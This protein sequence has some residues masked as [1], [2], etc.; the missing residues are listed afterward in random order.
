MLR[1]R[2][3]AEACAVCLLLTLQV[4]PCALAAEP[5][6]EGDTFALEG[7]TA[8]VRKLEML[9][10]VENEMTKAFVFDKAANPKL[11][12]LRTTYRLDEVIATGRT[13]F[14][15]QLRLM[16]WVHAQWRW[17][18][19]TDKGGMRDAL[20]ILRL[21]RKEQR[22]YC[23]QFAAVLVSASASLGYVCRPM[24]IRGHSFTEMWSNDHRKWVLFDPTTNYYPERD[25]VPLSTYEFRH[26]LCREGGKGVLRASWRG[27]Q[28]ARRP[29][30]PGYGRRLL[31]LGYIPNTDLMDRGE[32]SAGMFITKDD[33]CEGQQWREGR[34]VKEPAVDPYFPIN[35]ATLSLSPDGDALRVGMKTLTPNFKTFRVRVDEGE[36]SDCAE[37]RT[38]NP[39]RGRN[40][41]EA[42][43]VNEFGV[44][45][46]VSALEL[47][48]LPNVSARATDDG[49][50]VIA[51]VAFS[52]EGGGAVGIIE[53][54]SEVT[55]A[56]VHYWHTPGHWLE[57]DVAVP[58]PGDYGLALRYAA[59]FPTRRELSVNGRAAKGHDSLILEPT[60]GWKTWKTVTLPGTVRLKDGRNTLR[61]ACRDETSVRLHQ[62][63]LTRR[64]REMFSVEGVAFD[65]ED[66]GQAQKAASD[67]DGYCR[68]WTDE[69]HWMEWTI[70]DAKPGRYDLFLSYATLYRSP[71]QVQ[72]NGQAAE[73]LDSFVM[74]LTGGWRRFVENKAPAP[75]WLRAGRNVL[76]MTSLGGRGFNFAG[77]RLVGED[78][79]EIYIPGVSFTGEG[80]GKVTR[81][82]H[83][84]HGHPHSWDNKGHWL[85]WTLEAAT[86]G[87]Y[88][89]ALRYATR[90]RAPR[91]LRVNGE[92]AEGLASFT[93]EP[94]GDWR[95][96]AE[97]RLPA[98]VTLKAG[99]NVLR[100]TSLGGG[101]NVDE[102]QLTKAQAP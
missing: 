22:F 37:E 66:G 12:E 93:V 101:L 5:L 42:K 85:E 68:F 58:A 84:R 61:I 8:I 27:G 51:G 16:E 38:W 79:D 57:W 28:L 95:A 1:S 6:K 60:G 7:R 43:S 59:Q 70:D 21:V 54:Y 80:G 36:W 65:R 50:I 92:V 48:V 29:Q 30:D 32:V 88:D 90:D 11:A 69:G 47:Q 15:K 63:L 41:L 82:G 102:I 71:R 74:P 91:E 76:R 39:R 46:P 83:A 52:G 96:W 53:R 19:P 3:I 17:D 49:P 62:V 99:R 10:Y 73:G 23:S 94:T 75:V 26:A 78:R 86:E 81:T 89:V 55:P 14:E 13:Q 64:G 56:H 98:P 18:D 9:P 97:A 24:S 35:Q 77:L 31:F 4:T 20:E 67:R 33:L 44:E 25:G 40:V 45:G 100:M 2:A 72:V 87:R 34:Y